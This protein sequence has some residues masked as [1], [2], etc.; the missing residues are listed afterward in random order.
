MEIVKKE[1]SIF[2][3]AKESLLMEV[4]EQAIP[5]LKPFLVPAMAKMNEW[6][7]EDEKLILIRKNKGG[8][9]QVVIFDNSVGDYEIKKDAVN[10]IN[11]FTADQKCIM[12]VYPIEDFVEK[13][14][15]GDISKLMEGK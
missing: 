8:K 2:D 13:M 5:K 11:I 1:S 14:I 15:T 9:A 4:V 6:F 10:N 12:G 7:G 3:Q